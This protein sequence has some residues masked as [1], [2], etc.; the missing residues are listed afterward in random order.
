MDDQQ[1]PGRPA[2]AGNARPAGNA[3]L[4]LGTPGHDAAAERAIRPQC[5]EGWH[6]RGH[7]PRLDVPGLV[8]SVTF[9]LA[10]SLPREVLN[11]L[12]REL[13]AQPASTRPAELR[14]RVDAWLDAGTGCC[15]LGH[16]R[17]AAVVQ[18][19]LLRFDGE[20]YR[21]LAWCVM[22]NHVHVLVEPME[23]LARIVQSWKSF[24]G[25]WAL[26]HD[27]EL[28]LGIPGERLWMRDYWNRYIRD[29]RHYH[30]VLEYI[31]WNPVNAGLC[32]APDAWRWSSARCARDPGP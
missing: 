19:A 20:R 29:D 30:A 28:G 13:R 3:E 17:V 10:D 32:A 22:P 26:A 12:D 15:A 23:S 27:G 31:H 5:P 4:Q 9:R 7:V 8:Q 25:R 21:L 11:R 16:P 2:P 1:R 14:R 18:D 24:T 6:S